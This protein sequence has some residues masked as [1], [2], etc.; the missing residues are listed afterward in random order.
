MWR[1]ILIACACVAFSSVTSGADVIFEH[2][3]VAVRSQVPDINAPKAADIALVIGNGAYAEEPLRNASSDAHAMDAALR[4]LGYEVVLLENLDRS[5]M[6]AAVNGFLERIRT[7]GTAL[8]YFSGHGFRIG[9]RTLLAPVDIQRDAPASLIR[10][11]IDLQPVLD[12]L[13][14]AR[15]RGR[16]LVILDT[17]LNNPFGGPSA[18]LSAPP[19]GTVVAYATVPGG[20]AAE[21]K[22]NGAFTEALLEAL[23]AHKSDDASFLQRAAVNL[24]Q[25][26]QGRQLP[27]VSASSYRAILPKDSAEQYE[28]TFWESIKDSKDPADYEAYLQ[29]YPKGRFAALA[30]SRIE[31]LRAAAKQQAP[32]DAPRKTSVPEKPR[33][34][35]RAAPE[36]PAPKERT[37]PPPAPAARPEQAPA[38]AAKV[39]RGAVVT[40]CPTSPVLI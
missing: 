9:D 23:H 31:R 4:R 11:G 29:A 12:R 24:S 26:S 19:S 14:A 35:P 37:E 13:S 32:A 8:L 34:A 20:L 3:R 6:E 18:P 30:K 2:E 25:A 28:L 1:K 16:N 27:I 21:G 38:P 22:R 39:P 36:R 15:P 17:C 5:R 40:D 33:P 7:S 10:K